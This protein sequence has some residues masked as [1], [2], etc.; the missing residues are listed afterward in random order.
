MQNNESVSSVC[1]DE[2]TGSY[3]LWCAY[4]WCDVVGV[5]VGGNTNGE[6]STE[7]VEKRCIGTRGG[8]TLSC[9]IQFRFC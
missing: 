8:E 4:G 2:I 5:T 6:L 7:D 3:R 9:R 1:G